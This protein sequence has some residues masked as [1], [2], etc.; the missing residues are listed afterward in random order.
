MRTVLPFVW[1]RQQPCLFSKVVSQSYYAEKI[2]V[3]ERHSS[4]TLIKTSDDYLGWCEGFCFDEPKS[5][6]KVLTVSTLQA[7]VYDRKDTEYGPIMTLP[8]GV[9]VQLGTYEDERWQEVVLL[10]GNRAFMQKG[11]FINLNLSFETFCKIFLHLPYTWGGRTSFGFDCS[12]F[13]QMVYKHLGIKLIRDAKDQ[14][15]DSRFKTIL[16]DDIQ[17]KDLV[18]FGKNPHQ[19]GH[20]GICLNS[21][22]FIHTSSKENMPYLRI[23]SFTDYEW[24]ANQNSYYPYREFKRFNG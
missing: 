13:V 17:S 23:S 6:H 11:E 8:F 24:S 18:F 3:L 1:M 5:D 20:V 2:E 22:T 19:I 16:L 9:E 7:H 21:K 12:G 10:N 4:W 15:Q 14:I